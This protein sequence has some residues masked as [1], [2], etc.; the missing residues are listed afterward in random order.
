MRKQCQ[1]PQAS[2][3]HPA[4]PTPVLRSAPS[5]GLT[6]DAPALIC[7]ALKTVNKRHNTSKPPAALIQLLEWPTKSGAIYASHGSWASVM[8]ALI[9]NPGRQ[10][11]RVCGAKISASKT[12]A[13]ASAAK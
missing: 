11:V 13:S 8:P 9:H 5:A 6:S 3:P 10:R 2:R 12:E 1:P 4:L 7:P